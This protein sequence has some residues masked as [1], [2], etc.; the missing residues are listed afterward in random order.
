MSEK[1]R[2]LSSEEAEELVGGGS[3]LDRIG[4][5]EPIVQDDS[6]NDQQEIPPTGKPKPK[7]RD[8]IKL[9]L[10]LTPSEVN[11]LDRLVMKQR[12][13]TGRSPRRN[14][15]IR[16]AVQEYLRKRR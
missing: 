1:R 3:L 16:E 4:R 9:S 10:Y 11:S 12:S 14:Q 5:N 15:L 2:P 6:S 7:E 8:L 13:E